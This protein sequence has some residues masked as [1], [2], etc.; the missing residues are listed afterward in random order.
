MLHNDAKKV[1]NS[2]FI[3]YTSSLSHFLLVV[4]LLPHDAFTASSFSSI[5]F[6]CNNDNDTVNS[7]ESNSHELLN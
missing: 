1:Y 4:M 7:A 2:Y 5:N 3:T 6:K